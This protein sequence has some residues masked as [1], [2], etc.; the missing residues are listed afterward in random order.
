MEDEEVL[1]VVRDLFSDELHK[2]GDQLVQARITAEAGEGSNAVLVVG[3]VEEDFADLL[4][5][6]LEFFGE[7]MLDLGFDSDIVVAANGR[8]VGICARAFGDEVLVP[9]VGGGG[10]LGNGGLDAL[11]RQ[12]VCCMTVS[13]LAWKKEVGRTSQRHLTRNFREW[14]VDELLKIDF[15]VFNVE[16]RL[17]GPYRCFTKA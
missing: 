10:V 7:D 12:P 11:D 5:V 3:F 4:E 6:E 2:V 17:S 16:E 14:R 13:L 1:E 8:E 9:G 15:L